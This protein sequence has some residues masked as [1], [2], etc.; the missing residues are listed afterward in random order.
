MIYKL[1]DKQAN[2]LKETIYETKAKA[3]EARRN[4]FN[5]G[6]EECEFIGLK[7]I[8]YEQF[9]EDVSICEYDDNYN[10]VKE[11]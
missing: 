4:W 2:E 7:P 11:Y 10:L 9:C 1:Y 3:E 6:C 5:D 8:S